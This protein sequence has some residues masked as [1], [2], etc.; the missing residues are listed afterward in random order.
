MEN[1]N[2]KLNVLGLVGMILG[3]LAVILSFVPCIGIYALFPGVLGLIFS[4]IGMKKVRKGMAI[5]GLVCSLIG[6]GVAAW[7]WYALSQ[8]SDELKQLNKEIENMEVE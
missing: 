5:A 7:Q 4:L 1:N 6:T 8:A 2:E 3:I